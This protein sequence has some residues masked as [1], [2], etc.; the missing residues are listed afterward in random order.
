MS[1]L[2][3]EFLQTAARFDRSGLD[4]LAERSFRVLLE[5]EDGGGAGV[6]DR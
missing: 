4:Y 5:Y 6:A 2:H 3:P 1:F